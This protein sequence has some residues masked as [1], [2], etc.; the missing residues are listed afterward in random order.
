MIPG[1]PRTSANCFCAKARLMQV[2]SQQEDK[3]NMRKLR[4]NCL[5]KG[6]FETLKGSGG[7]KTDLLSG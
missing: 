4:L 2:A 7:L 6:K 5:K 3:K 1:R